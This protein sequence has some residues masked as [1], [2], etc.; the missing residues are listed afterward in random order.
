MPATADVEA[1]EHHDAR[2]VFLAH[3][4]HVVEAEL[5]RAPL[6]EEAVRVYEEDEAEQADE[7][8][9]YRHEHADVRLAV[10]RALAELAE[11]RG[12]S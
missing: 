2:D 1:L 7:E 5:L 10:R 8:D 12:R 6:H 4:E 11:S 3:A 9:A